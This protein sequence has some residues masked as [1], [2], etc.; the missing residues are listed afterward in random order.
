MKPFFYFSI[1][2]FSLVLN[3]QVT[4]NADGAGNTY[5]LINS[6]LVPGGSAS[7]SAVEAPD[8]SHNPEERHIE[9]VY[10]NDLKKFVFKFI[11]HLMIDNDPETTST[12]RQRIEIKTYNPSPENLKARKNET[13]IYKW[14]FKIPLG[15][16]ISNKFT[17]I[18][19]IKPVD[20]DDKNPLFTLTLNK[21]SGTKPNRIELIY[22]EKD[23]I[24][25]ITLSEARLSEI[26]GIWVEATETIFVDETNGSFSIQ[27]KKVS[28]NE[29]LFNFSKSGFSTIRKT[30][31]YIRPKWGIYRTTKTTVGD[32]STFIPGLKDEVLYMSDISIS[33][34]ATMSNEIFLNSGQKI[35]K[36]NVINDFLEIDEANFQEFSI[37]DQTGKILL[38]K[39]INIQTIIDVSNFP[40]GIYY[41]R[42][43]NNQIDKFIKR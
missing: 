29:I 7:V 2:L 25:P 10:D 14:R 43:N 34:L 42:T 21:A 33:E 8:K 3:S 41:I 27:L 15:F 17:H 19:Q 38:S 35:L 28:N 20:G 13:V 22:D 31:S 9:E 11:S 1:F 4:L 30:N 26:E 16:G 24:A 36:S 39:A 32:V 12:E 18:H 37:F 23:L 40:S 5:E 6:V